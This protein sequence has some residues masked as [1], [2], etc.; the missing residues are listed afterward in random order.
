MWFFSQGFVNFS[1]NCSN[2]HTDVV[3]IKTVCNLYISHLI[4]WILLTDRSIVWTF[5]LATSSHFPS[6]ISSLCRW[7]IK[8]SRRATPQRCWPLALNWQQTGGPGWG[9][10]SHYSLHIAYTIV[11]IIILVWTFAQNWYHLAAKLSI[12]AKMNF[13][14]RSLGSSKNFFWTPGLRIL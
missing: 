7:W 2:K 12:V 13:S 3:Y 11:L 14:K 8:L 4:V 9:Q 1:Q 6:S 5:C 10:V